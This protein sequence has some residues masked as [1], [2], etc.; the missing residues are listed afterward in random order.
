[1]HIFLI[2]PPILKARFNLYTCISISSYVSHS[3]IQTETASNL[4]FFVCSHRFCDLFFKFCVMFFVCFCSLSDFHQ[5]LPF[6]EIMLILFNGLFHA[7]PSFIFPQEELKIPSSELHNSLFFLH[8][9]SRSPNVL[10][11][12]PYRHISL[13]LIL[14]S[15]E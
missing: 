9:A 3:K 4:V 15:L 2:Y 6:H 12:G 7:Y 13:E 14:H 5:A 8:E 10:F 11:M 1:M